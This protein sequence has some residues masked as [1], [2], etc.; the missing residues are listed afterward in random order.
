MYRFSVNKKKTFV[1]ANKLPRITFHRLDLSHVK[2]YPTLYSFIA[3]P[4]THRSVF[5]IPPLPCVRQLIE[6]CDCE[7]E[8]FL[9]LV[10]RISSL[11]GFRSWSLDVDCCFDEYLPPPSL[12]IKSRNEMEMTEKCKFAFKSRQCRRIS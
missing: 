5:K 1:E 12:R 3:S 11:R 2:L 6:F 10:L 9:L 8:R 4:P 7:C